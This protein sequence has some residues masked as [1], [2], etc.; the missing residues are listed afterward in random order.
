MPKEEGYGGEAVNFCALFNNGV[1]A[2]TANDDYTAS[3]LRRLAQPLRITNKNTNGSDVTRTNDEA[4]VF[5]ESR[6]S[7]RL[8]KKR[9]KTNGDN[10]QMERK[11]DWR[12]RARVRLADD[13]F[14]MKTRPPTDR[15]LSDKNRFVIDL[16]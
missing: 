16:D 7:I 13:V 8:G 4:T 1:N 12:L 15:N 11:R 9:K 5:Y 14:D 3:R 10:C 6:K 2:F